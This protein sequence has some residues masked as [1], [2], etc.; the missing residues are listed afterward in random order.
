MERAFAD[1]ALFAA[2]LAVKDLRIAT[3]I[4]E[5]PVTAAVSEHLVRAA[6][7]D[8]AL[9]RADLARTAAHLIRTR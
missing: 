3:A 7:D 8:P 2:E 6:E 1:G 4:A 9:A 5:L